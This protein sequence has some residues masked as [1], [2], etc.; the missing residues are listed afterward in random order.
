[1]CDV[2]WWWS[3]WVDCLCVC[4]CIVCVFVYLCVLFVANTEV[5]VLACVYVCECNGDS[6]KDPILT[7][8]THWN[9]VTVLNS[10]NFLSENLKYKII[11]LSFCCSVTLAL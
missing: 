7:F 2:L 3:G 8:L 6:A 11:C 9:E 4:V 5:C 1:M 10:E